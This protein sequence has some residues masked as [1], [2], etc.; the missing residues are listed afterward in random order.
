MNLIRRVDTRLKVYFCF[1]LLAALGAALAWLAMEQAQIRSRTLLWAGVATQAVLGLGLARWLAGELERPLHEA[2][3]LA[4]RIAAGDLSTQIGTP[5]PGALGVLLASLQEMNDQLLKV[6]A[7]VRDGTGALSGAAGVVAGGALQLALH[8]ERHAAAL[9]NIALAIEAFEA[10]A[11]EAQRAAMR[12]LSQEVAA[13]EQDLHDNFLLAQQ[14]GEAAAVVRDQTG[15]VA[16]LMRGFHLGPGYEQAGSHIHLVSINRHPLTRPAGERR[17]PLRI[18][19]V[20][21]AWH[22]TMQGEQ[23]NWQIYMMAAWPF[24]WHSSYSQLRTCPIAQL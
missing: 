2:A 5:A 23:L 13:L 7:K 10:G 22:G 11:G 20:T 16:R 21:P 4:R 1:A 3:G 19:A 24:C 18:A 12:Q 14:C 9:H 6:I 15:G 8:G 17:K